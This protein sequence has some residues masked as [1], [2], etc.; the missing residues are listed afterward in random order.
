M[1]AVN[2]P[3][4]DKIIKSNKRLK[5]A[6]H[7]QKSKRLNHRVALDELDTFLHLIDNAIDAMND[8]TIEIEKTQEKL[9]ELYDFCGEVP[10]DDSC[11][12]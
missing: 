8:T 5:T 1:C 7:S 11:D 10:M 4:L 9:Y 2:K 12:Y 3:N 6:F